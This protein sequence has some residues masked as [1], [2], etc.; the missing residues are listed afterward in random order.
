MKATTN[1][2]TIRKNLGITP[3]MILAARADK[4][5]GEGA[6][7]IGLTLGLDEHYRPIEFNRVI[8]RIEIMAD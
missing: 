8:D 5:A 6:Y 2:Q 7:M 4:E 3:A 1:A